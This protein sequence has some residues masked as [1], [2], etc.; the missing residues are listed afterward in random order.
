[1]TKTNLLLFFM[2]VI[3]MAVKKCFDS[4][5]IT[6]FRITTFSQNLNEITLSIGASVPNLSP[7]F[8]PL[9]QVKSFHNIL[10]EGISSTSLQG[11]KH[12]L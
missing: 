8:F 6:S 11:E 4:N 10:K 5:E 9:L 12:W 2:N 3:M 1:M 7:G